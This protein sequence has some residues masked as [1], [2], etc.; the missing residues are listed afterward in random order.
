MTTSA[1]EGDMHP[2]LEWLARNV[3]EW[4]G[5]HQLLSK[6]IGSN[7]HKF[8]T[9]QNANYEQHHDYYG[10]RFDYAQWLQARKDLGLDNG[11]W[12]PEAIKAAAF[13]TPEEDEAWQAK[14]RSLYGEIKE[15]FDSMADNV[16]H[17]EHYQSD[18]GIECIDSIRAALGLDGFVAHCR[19]T[20]IKY[21]WRSGK[22]QAH[23]ED[24][25]KAAWYLTRAAEALESAK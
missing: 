15:G 10:N 16:N 21:S 24:L 14:E 25:R 22:K 1:R 20:A 5:D 4:S 8:E 6:R 23:A 9:L 2:D 18:N 12:T 17:P 13:S 3:S 19:G 11:G 7:A